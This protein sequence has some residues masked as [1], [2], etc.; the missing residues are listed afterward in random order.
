MKEQAWG[1]GAGVWNGSQARVRY[2]PASR[3]A[4]AEAPAVS[5]ITHIRPGVEEC[6]LRFMAHGS[7]I[8]VYCLWLMVWVTGRR[9]GGAYGARPPE[10]AKSGAHAHA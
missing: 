4:G 10:T 2:G 9:A 7:P 1:E 3:S 8:M 6:G 5:F